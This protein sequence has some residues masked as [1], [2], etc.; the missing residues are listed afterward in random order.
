MRI[1]FY[2]NS[3]PTEEVSYTT[4][5]LAHTAVRRGHEVFYLAAEDLAYLPDGSLG[6]HGWRAPTKRMRTDEAF[7]EAVRGPDAVREWVDLESLDVIMLRNDPARDQVERPWAVGI[8]L[9][10]GEEAARRGVMVLND[11]A[12]LARAVN[13]M[14]LQ[15]FPVEVR[16]V[17]L[18]TR[19]SGAVKEFV[20]E[21]MEQ[22]VVIKP[23]SGSGGE[24]VFL[25]KG[26]DVSNLNQILDA[27]R[28]YGYLIAQEYLPAARERDTRII[29]LNGRPLEVD[30][31]IAAFSRVNREG[32]LRTNITAGGGTEPARITDRALELA[33]LVRPRLVRDGMFMVGLD[34]AGDK[35]ME[36]N[37]FSPG[38][39]RVASRYQE[40]EFDAAVID[41]IEAK[42]EHRSQYDGQMRNVELA[43]L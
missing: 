25:V 15:S 11:P 30:G 38:G 41:A 7:L 29:L 18:I 39:L 1:A 42:L 2:V 24:S 32:D 20:R 19:D 17:T 34:V 43:T 16:P 4:T 33:E 6:G 27:V 40:V 35:L 9:L 28:K 14:Y 12:G 8:G 23:L 21:R 37:V 31:K 13:K 10:F 5:L 26:D 3:L 36:I 22:G